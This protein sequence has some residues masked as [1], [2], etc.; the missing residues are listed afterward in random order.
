M[1]LNLPLMRNNISRAD[2]DAVIAHLKQGPHP[3]SVQQ[4]EAFE[5]EW[6][7]WLGVNYG[8]FVIQGLRRIN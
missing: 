6:S 7:A 3:D 4:R 1:P 5:E 2:L 8:V